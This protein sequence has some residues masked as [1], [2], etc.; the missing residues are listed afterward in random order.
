MLTEAVKLLKINLRTGKAES[1]TEAVATEAPVGIY[2]NGNHLTTILASPEKLNKLALGFLIGGGVLKSVEEVADMKVENLS[3]KI[4][5][6][7]DV[8]TRIRAYHTT[9][10]ITTSCGSV[11]AFIRLLDRLDIVHVDSKDAVSPE[12]I[13]QAVAE[14]NKRSSVFRLTGGTHAATILTFDGEPVAFAED[15][16][17]HNAVDKVIGEAI[18]SSANLPRCI[19]ASTGRQSSDMV[20]KV[21]RVRIPILASIAAPLHSGVHAAEKTGVTLVCFVRGSRM[22][23]YTHP[24]RVAYTPTQEV[25]RNAALNPDTPQV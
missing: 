25:P 1:T 16:G 13:L 14:L 2:L 7:G 23:V 3:V 4:T 10:L 15:V 24:E 5:T 8:E 17:R 11:E 22:N 18:T 19:V 20:L 21:A 12:L 6:K 9:R